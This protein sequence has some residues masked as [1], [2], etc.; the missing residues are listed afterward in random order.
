V[1]VFL[2]MARSIVLSAFF[3]II[4]ARSSSLVV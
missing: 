3:F 2:A 1:V 4:M